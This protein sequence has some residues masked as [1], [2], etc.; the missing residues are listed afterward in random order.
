MG[1]ENNGML[2]DGRVPGPRQAAEEAVWSA[3][4]REWA[5]DETA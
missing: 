3:A 1:S 4:V 5:T 2:V